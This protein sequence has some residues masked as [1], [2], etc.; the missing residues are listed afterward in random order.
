MGDASENDYS[1]SSP[2]S[3]H[4][5]SEKLP[6]NNQRSSSDEGQAHNSNAGERGVEH[7]TFNDK[8]GNPAA[9]VLND[10]AYALRDAA[11]AL[12]EVANALQQIE[13]AVTNSIKAVSSKTEKRKTE[14]E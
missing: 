7:P 3:R 14:D 13:A 4:S 8:G 1:S 11:N 9:D 5:R 10:A 6:L 2:C 12:R